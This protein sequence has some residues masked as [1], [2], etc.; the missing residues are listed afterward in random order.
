MS[1]PVISLVGIATG[2]KLPLNEKMYFIVCEE[3]EILVKQATY[4]A[5]ELFGA[6]S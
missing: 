6:G 5:G 2:N 3:R 1:V 4:L